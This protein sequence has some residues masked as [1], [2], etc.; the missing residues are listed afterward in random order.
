[1]PIP[2]PGQVRRRHEYTQSPMVLKREVALEPPIELAWR[3]VASPDSVFIHPDRHD[4]TGKPYFHSRPVPLLRVMGD[5]PWAPAADHR[6][7]ERTAGL[8]QTR[9]CSR[10]IG[11]VGYAIERTEIGI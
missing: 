3:V 9:A 2:H 8:Q 7:H 1:M 6:E 10:Y 11:Q 4:I 5:L